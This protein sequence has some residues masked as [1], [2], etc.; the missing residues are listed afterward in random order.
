METWKVFFAFIDASFSV[1]A[2]G[3]GHTGLVIMWGN[4]AVAVVSKKQ[5]IGK[6]VPQSQR[7]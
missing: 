4:A 7:W 5:K 1:H 6:K 3:K 2:D